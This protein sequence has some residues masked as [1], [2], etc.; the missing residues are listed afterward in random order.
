MLSSRRLTSESGV[1]DEISEVD[2]EQN[3]FCDFDAKS[4]DVCDSAHAAR[5]RLYFLCVFHKTFSV[6]ADSSHTDGY[7]R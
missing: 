4:C 6:N 7:K 3:Q 5:D 1:S 2:R